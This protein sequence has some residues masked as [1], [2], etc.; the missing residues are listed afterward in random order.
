[1]RLFFSPAGPMLRYREGVL[2]ISDLNPERDVYW[3]LSR[4]EVFVIGLR[5]MMAAFRR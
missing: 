5:F 1:M 3:A 2:K 4:K